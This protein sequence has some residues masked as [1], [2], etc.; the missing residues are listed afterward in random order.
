MTSRVCGQEEESVAV[1]L[2]CR[3]RKDILRQVQLERMLPARQL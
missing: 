3:T 2:L 1:H